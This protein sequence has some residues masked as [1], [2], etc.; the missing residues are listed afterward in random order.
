[1]YDHRREI[2]RLA[3]EKMVVERELNRK[4][5]ELRKIQETLKA[6]QEQ[7]KWSV[8]KQWDLAEE[9]LVSM[10]EKIRTEVE[11][12]KS[13]EEEREKASEEKE[14]Y[15]EHS[16]E[17][18]L[19]WER[20]YTRLW[21]KTRVEREKMEQKIKELR[22]RGRADRGKIESLERLARKNWTRGYYDGKDANRH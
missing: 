18:R 3:N 19:Y 17:T 12:R 20:A 5:E 22:E 8:N 9:E 4:R 15:R 21:N 13:A 1:M 16:E 11:R 7:Y 10:T 6:T 2:A 14:Q